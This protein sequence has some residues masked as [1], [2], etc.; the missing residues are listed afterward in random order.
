M[1]SFF[2]CVA[3]MA[4][5]IA[6]NSY[7]WNDI[8]TH[9]TLSQ[10]AATRVFDNDFLNISFRQGGV[11]RTVRDWIREGA[12]REDDWAWYW[13]PT[14]RSGN[15]FHAPNRSLNRTGWRETSGMSTPLWAQDKTEQ[16][17]FFGGDWSW[18]TVRDHLYNYVTA[19]SKEAEDDNLVKMLKGLG[20]QMHLVQDM[21][22]PNHV[23]DDTHI[24]DGFGWKWIVNGFE[25]WAK[26][27]D[28]KVIREQIL[29]KKDAVGENVYPVPEVQVDLTKLFNDD[30]TKAP[31]ARLSD[32]REGM[33]VLVKDAANN[34]ISY[35]ITPSTSLSQGLAQYTNSNFFSESTA[36]AADRYAP[37]ETRY[38]FPYPRKSETNLQD[39]IDNYLDPVVRTD[40]DGKSY[41]T[42]QIAKQN[43]TGEP[44]NCLTMPGPNTLKFFEEYGGEGGMFYSSFRLDESCM[45]E[46]AEKLIPRTVGYSAAMLNYFLRGNL[47]VTVPQDMLPT[48]KQIRLNVRNNTQTGEAMNGGSVDLMV[49]F[50]Q[51]KK[52]GTASAGTLVPDGDYIF[53]K[54][55]LRGCTREN[56]V[57]TIDTSGTSLDF[58]L[59]ND[60]LP[61]LARDV[62]LIVVYRGRLGNEPDA[63]AYEQIF[64]DGVAG[65]LDISL[66]PRGVYASVSGESTAKTFNDFALTAKNTSPT[67][68][69]PGSTELLV[70]FRDAL[71]NPFLSQ[72][73]DSSPEIKYAS[74]TVADQSSIPANGAAE[75]L[76][77]LANAQIPVTATD[78]YVYLIHT[79]QDGTTVHGYRDISEPTPVDIFNNT[80]FVCLQNEWHPAGEPST[81]TLADQLGNH[82]GSDDDIDAFRHDLANIYY[83][84]TSQAQPVTVSATDYTFFEPGSVAPATVK[85][86]GFVLTDYALQYSSMRDFV[87]IDPN[88]GWIGGVGTVATLE[89]G[90]GVRNQTDA[91]GKY[92]Y[93]LMYNM[94][95]KPMWGSTGT[96]YGN[97][98]LPVNSTC[99]WS[100]LPVVP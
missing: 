3:V 12:E 49:I 20:Y 4:I 94:R 99:D 13:P 75:L 87:H 93:P 79:A 8:E 60:P 68:T 15:H 51:Y 34:P 41:K 92:T 58:D 40:V 53:R 23:R 24:P 66:P 47:T 55:S 78:V 43:T 19:T 82:N 70:I 11:E 27:N 52:N 84:L 83:E 57:C 22:Q 6:G 59:S 18:G 100:L 36:F 54:Y 71:G 46:Y 9:P 67:A 48:S 63:V 33:D 85:R 7:G 30:P 74:A 50:R 88:D 73:V 69:G 98:K 32:T 44:L 64:L 90:M 2:Y 89:P 72:P 35:V 16:E 29:D 91:S 76:F 42:F 96:I 62:S 86:L 37:T 95:G 80:D 38:H 97:G 65:D 39:F 26:D 28:I 5:F 10:Y 17:K 31:V 56:P 77:S 61:P 14:A 45:K 81:I 25:T 21:S 1:K